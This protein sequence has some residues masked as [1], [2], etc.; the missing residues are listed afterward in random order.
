MSIGQNKQIKLFIKILFTCLK[1][2]LPRNHT[3]FRVA[4]Q[5]RFSNT[6]AFEQRSLNSSALL[7]QLYLNNINNMGYKNIMSCVSLGYKNI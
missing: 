4:Q 1:S 3:L 6:I 5:K 7:T 2:R